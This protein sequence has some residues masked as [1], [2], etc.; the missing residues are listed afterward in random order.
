MINNVGAAGVVN[1][2]LYI[3]QAVMYINLTPVAVQ[4]IY[5]LQRQKVAAIKHPNAFEPTINPSG[6]F[7]PNCSVTIK[8]EILLCTTT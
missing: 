2:S 7:V 4:Q 1:L 8:S 5:I 6:S 3:S